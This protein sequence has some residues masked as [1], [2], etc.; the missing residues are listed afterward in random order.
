MQ[1][2]DL[3]IL[4]KSLYRH[5]LQLP[6]LCIVY[7]KK[8]VL[9]NTIKKGIDSSVQLTARKP[10][11]QMIYKAISWLPDY[12]YVSAI[13]PREHGMRW[14]HYFYHIYRFCIKTPSC[15]YINYCHYLR[16]YIIINRRRMLP[17]CFCSSKHNSKQHGRTQVILS[18]LHYAVNTHNMAAATLNIDTT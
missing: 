1:R 3:A 15:G 9:E 8:T 13:C 18:H 17:G 4:Q 10:L 12:S 11:N 2:L 14:H 16:F 6:R 5:L 7:Y